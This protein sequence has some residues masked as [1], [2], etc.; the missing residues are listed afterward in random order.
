MILSRY[1]KK[2]N[3]TIFFEAKTNKNYQDDIITLY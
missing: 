3:S 2:M 1:N